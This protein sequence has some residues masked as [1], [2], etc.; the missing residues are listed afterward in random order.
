MSTVSGA[1][2]DMQL[3]AALILRNDTLGGRF[4]YRNNNASFQFNRFLIRIINHENNPHDSP[5]ALGCKVVSITISDENG[6]EIEVRDLQRGNGRKHT[7]AKFKSASMFVYK[8]T[9]AH[10]A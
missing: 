6:T 2:D 8:I 3:A 7:C 1:L 10:C 4:E 9:S 5:R